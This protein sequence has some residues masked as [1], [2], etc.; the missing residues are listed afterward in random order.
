M[1]CYAIKALKRKS[2]R[3]QTGPLRTFVVAILIHPSHYSGG[4]KSV[5]EVQAL[6]NL[7]K[8]RY[9]RHQPVKRSIRINVLANAQ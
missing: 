3:R 2:F 1:L 7:T 9:S 8:Q 6:L 5:S 4:N